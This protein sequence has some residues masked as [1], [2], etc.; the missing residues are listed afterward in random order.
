VAR[1][2]TLSLRERRV[3]IGGTA[4]LAVA[5]VFTYAVMPFARHWREREGQDR[6]ARTRVAYLG[7]LVERTD[8][9]EAEATRCGARAVIA[10][11]AR[12]ACAVIDAGGQRIADVPAGSGRCQSRRG[13]ASRGV[14]D[15]SSAVTWQP[16]APAA[17]SKDRAPGGTRV[18]ATLSAYGD[19]SGAATLLNTL[20]TGPRVLLLD[21]LTLTRNA[22][23]AGAPDVVQ[24]TMT[25]RAP[26]LPQ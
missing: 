6:S 26:V 9:L 5:L 7:N 25:L 13:H 15:D 2:D 18:P 8:A 3:I 10:A 4:I 20:M 21:R 1:L 16:G 22:A 24:L 23:L 14:A 17:G 19:I 12:A 11:Q